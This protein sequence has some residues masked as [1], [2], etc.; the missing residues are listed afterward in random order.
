MQLLAQHYHLL[1]YHKVIND[2][3]IQIWLGFHLLLYYILNQ[4]INIPDEQTI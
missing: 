2:Y 3:F 1:N 4:H